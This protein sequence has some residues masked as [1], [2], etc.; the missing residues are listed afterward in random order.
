MDII[1][2]L[3]IPSLTPSA[4]DKAHVLAAIPAAVHIFWLI[5]SVLSLFTY[6]R[7]G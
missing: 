2:Y 5:V 6:V 7:G 4:S 1:P 3:D